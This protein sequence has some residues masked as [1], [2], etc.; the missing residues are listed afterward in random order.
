MGRT[1]CD[2]LIQ[3]Q[4]HTLIRDLLEANPGNGKLRVERRRIDIGELI[5]QAMRPSAAEKRVARS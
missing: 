1:D 3:C 4:L 2:P 5:Q